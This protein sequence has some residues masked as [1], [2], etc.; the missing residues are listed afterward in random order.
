MDPR[1]PCGPRMRTTDLDQA[2]LIK[3][4]STSLSGSVEL[5]WKC[6]YYNS[7][8]NNKIHFLFKTKAMNLNRNVETVCFAVQSLYGTVFDV[9]THNCLRRQFEDIVFGKKWFRNLP[10]DLYV[11]LWLSLLFLGME[12]RHERQFRFMPSTYLKLD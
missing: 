12:I 10:L 11:C 2:F 9:C 5:Q 6:W 8:N 7:N 3:G 1:G 4:S